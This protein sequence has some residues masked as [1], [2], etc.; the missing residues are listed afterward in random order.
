M[1]AAA[2]IAQS[3]TQA[4]TIRVFLVED[5]SVIRDRLFALLNA[6]PGVAVKGCAIDAPSAVTAILANPPDV[7]VLDLQLKGSSGLDVLRSLHDAHPALTVII[8]TNY[9]TPEYRK[10]C[11][12]AGAR[13]FLDKT[14]EFE[15][16][17]G[18]LGQLKSNHP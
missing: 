7:V 16:L 1:N 17:P 9:A 10:R 15:S 8:L 4:P 13:F 6:I 3:Q 12:E 5:S 2:H 14:H 11:L 18:I